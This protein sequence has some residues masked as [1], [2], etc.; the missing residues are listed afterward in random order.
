LHKLEDE[1]SGEVFYTKIACR[2]LDE[3][4]RCTHYQERHEL[5]PMCVWLKPEDIE[6]FHWLPSTCAYRLVAEG[7]PLPQWH[8]LISNNTDSV[9]EA[10]VSVK[11]RALNEEYVHPDGFDEHIIT[12]VE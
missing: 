8:P 3:S 9:H 6:A 11:G 7:K 10:G 4:C 12:W 5:V 2:Y 1:D